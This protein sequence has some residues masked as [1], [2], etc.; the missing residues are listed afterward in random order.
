MVSKYSAVIRQVKED[1]T[2]FSFLA[3][4]T[5]HQ[6]EDIND[7]DKATCSRTYKISLNCVNSIMIES[8]IKM[9]SNT[10]QIW[11]KDYY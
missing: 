5:Q 10:V 2:N 1:L 6:Q 11:L 3:V 7:Y 4:N 9:Y 8:C